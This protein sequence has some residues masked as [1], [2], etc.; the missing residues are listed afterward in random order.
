MAGVQELEA[1][2]VETVSLLKQ[3]TRKN[4]RVL[5]EKEERRLKQLIA[6]STPKATSSAKEISSTAT[7]RALPTSKITNAWDQSPKFVKIYITLDGIQTAPAD[8][9]K[10][11]FTERGFSIHINN[12][13]GKNH[14]VEM[15][16]LQYPIVTKD[17][18]VKQK[19]DML[20]VM[21]RKESEEKHWDEITRLDAELKKKN[22][23]KFD[24]P[25]SSSDP[26]ESL[27]SMMKDLY[28]K[29]DDEMKRTLRKARGST[30]ETHRWSRRFIGAPTNL[31]NNPPLFRNV[32]Q[33]RQG[34]FELTEV[35]VLVEVTHASSNLKMQQGLITQQ[36]RKT[37]N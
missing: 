4:A 32:R 22:A 6:E 12:F 14:V 23:P 31:Q 19:T 25:G 27:M 7:S 2:L 34:M 15:I 21:L 29:G 11:N 13:Q 17:S 36:Y 10:S 9:I 16:D 30:K 5:L 1:D 18:Y 28:D 33:R 8:L 3:A 26:N 24:T 20:L 35:D 37:N